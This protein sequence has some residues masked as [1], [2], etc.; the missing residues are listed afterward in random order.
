LTQT[1]KSICNVTYQT[2]SMNLINTEITL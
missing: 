2:G 1:V